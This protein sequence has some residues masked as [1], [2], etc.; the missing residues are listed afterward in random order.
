MSYRTSLLMLTASVLALAGTSATAQTADRDTVAE[1]VVTARR[2]SENQQDV[3]MSLTAVSGAEIERKG[4]STVLDLQRVAPSLTVSSNL[5]RNQTSFTIR[6]QRSTSSATGTGGGPS[7]IPYFAEAPFMANGPG[8]FFDLQNVQVLNGPQG[9]LFGQNTT[10]GAILFEPARPTTEPGGYVMGTLGNYNRREIEAVVN[11]PII[12]D[13]LLFRAG[14]QQQ[15]RD[16][17]TKDVVTGRD[18]DN[19]DLTNLRAGLLFTPFENLENYTVAYKTESDEN[20]PGVVLLAANP[21]KAFFTRLG[22]ALAAQQ[23][24]GI[25]A[26]SYD[27]RVLDRVQSV[28][29]VNR[30]TYSLTDNLTLTNIASWSRFQRDSGRDNDGTTNPIQ[31]SNGASIPGTWNSDNE[32]VTEELRASGYLADHLLQFQF[33]GYY[34]NNYP[35]G[36]Q[37]Y[38]QNLQAVSTSSQPRADSKA[39]SAAAFGQIGLDMGK[40]SPTFE[41]LNLT[42]GYRYT[43]N[44]FKFGLELLT[45]PGILY[46]PPA[47]QVGDGCQLP[48]GK[49]YPNCYYSAQGRS[50]GESFTFGADYKLG[51]DV[52][53]FANYKR[54]YKPGGFN[55]VV[56]ANGGSNQ[57]LGF[58]YD[59][60]NVDALEAGLKTDWRAG[61][62]SGYFNLTGYIN[63]Y[64]NIQVS[65]PLIIGTLTTAG[66][67]NA[68][69]AT[70]K[71]FEAAGSVRFNRVI[72][73]DANYSYIDAHYDRYMSGTVDLSGLPFLSTPR[74]QYNVSANFTLPVNDAIGAFVARANY[75]WSDTTYVGDTNPTQPFSFIKSYGLINARLEWNDILGRKIDAAIFATN[76]TNKTYRINVIQQYN[77]TGYTTA[78]FGEPRFYGISLR[79]RY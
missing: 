14:V 19:R 25:R 30:T 1:V 20:G 70:T 8:L 31:N 35:G 27:A 76:L 47:P 68:A 34:D 44:R 54:G 15:E 4:V 29:V 77:A 75:A 69:K 22:P 10:A 62:M 16:G 40:V 53:V 65:V 48:P 57:S 12:Q 61:E 9:T 71:G 49:K 56:I 33:G 32:I 3:P 21:A 51:N 28:G 38:T 39:M 26:V 78:I 43:W 42:A 74:N 55:S 58:S 63:K 7:V 66:I 5:S 17:F 59:P 13:K 50:E 72:S 24:R 67:Q 11:A 60:E 6:G 36:P 41:G 73:V 45:Y 79:A 2:V 64:D 52:L 37:T 46:P 23:A 18:Y